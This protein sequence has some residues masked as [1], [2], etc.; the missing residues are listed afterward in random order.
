MAKIP[1]QRTG[2][3]GWPDRRRAVS[4]KGGGDKKDGCWP[5][6]MLVIVA[7]GGVAAVRWPYAR[8][9]GLVVL[10]P[11]AVAAANQTGL[12]GGRACALRFWRG[13]GVPWS[14]WREG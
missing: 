10:S 6:V 1:R 2:S 4:Y 5:A 11:P 7:V 13:Y 8:L 14:L 12:R 9:S 3:G